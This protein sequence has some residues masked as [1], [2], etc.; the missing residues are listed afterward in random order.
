[1]MSRLHLRHGWLLYAH[2]EVSK[3]MVV[4]GDV[5]AFELSA[6]HAYGGQSLRV[7]CELYRGDVRHSM[8]GAS[9][10]SMM[11]NALQDWPEPGKDG[12]KWPPEMLALLALARNHPEEF[13]RLREGEAVLN[14]LGGL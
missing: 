12:R 2:P 10:E 7:T 5:M 14:A 11:W 6:E 3:G 8:N 9:L 1:M 4:S 13:E